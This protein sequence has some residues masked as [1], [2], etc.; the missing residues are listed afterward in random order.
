[1]WHTG[2][3]VTSRA[4]WGSNQYTRRP[5]AAPTRLVADLLGQAEAAG[6]DRR[7]PCQQ[8]WGPACQVLVGPPN[9]SQGE[10][11][12]LEMR[13]QATS[14][15]RPTPPEVLDWLADDLDIQ[16]RWQ[17]AAHPDTPPATLDRL[18]HDQVMMVREPLPSN[19]ATAPETL[20]RLAAEY[21]LNIR[22]ET[23]RNP[24]TPP[25]A[26]DA[27]AGSFETAALVAANPGVPLTILTRLAIHF[28]PKVRCAAASNPN[29]STEI[30][31]RLLQDPD[32]SVST[33]A[34]NNERLPRSTVAMWQLAR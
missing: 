5:G 32:E 16:V 4:G 10:H 31:E 12:T 18:S 13:R 19:P 21:N 9:W 3:V 28:H 26:L 11:P 6:V 29:A 17:V 24:R 27:L 23:A 1:M 15:W 34:V 20:G 22:T 7:R 30:L 2:S 33:A 14:D 8:V 25:A